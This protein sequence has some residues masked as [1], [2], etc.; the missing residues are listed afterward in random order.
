MSD[1]YP[2]YATW[3]DLVALISRMRWLPPL[4]DIPAAAGAAG[5]VAPES[6]LKAE[7]SAN[8]EADASAAAASSAA[9]A[10]AF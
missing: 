2:E 8:S 9:A 7:P 5:A 10:G 6:G 4:W 1:G 3:G